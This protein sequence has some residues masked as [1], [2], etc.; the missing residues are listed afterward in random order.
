M[1]TSLRRDEIVQR[2]LALPAEVLSGSLLP[3]DGIAEVV[4]LLGLPASATLVD[5]ACGRGGYRLEVAAR[6]GASLIGIDFSVEAIRQAGQCADALGRDARFVVADIAATGLRTASVDGVMCIDAIHIVAEPADVFAELRRVLRPGGRVVVSN[7]EARDRDN[8]ALPEWVRRSTAPP[9]SPRQGSPTSPSSSGRCG[10]SRNGRCGPKRPSSTRPE[11]TPSPRS[12]TRRSRSCRTSRSHDGCSHRPPR[13][14]TTH[15]RTDPRERPLAGSRR[16]PTRQGVPYCDQEGRRELLEQ[17]RHRCR[18]SGGRGV[19]T[20]GRRATFGARVCRRYRIRPG[21]RLVRVTR[22]RPAGLECLP[23]ASSGAGVPG[24]TGYSTSC[25]PDTD[26]G[27][28]AKRCCCRERD[29]IRRKHRFASVVVAAPSATSSRVAAQTTK[30]GG[31][32]RCWPGCER[33]G[34]T[35]GRTATNNHV[36]GRLRARQPTRSRTGR[37]SRDARRPGASRGRVRSPRPRRRGRPGGDRHQPAP[38]VGRAGRSR[39]VTTTRAPRAFLPSSTGCKRRC[40]WSRSHG[41]RD[42][43]F[44]Q[45]EVRRFSSPTA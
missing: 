17:G 30:V 11:T 10:S 4:E 15:L 45:I 37:R 33:G 28:P 43:P 34:R 9:G 38:A 42:H 20:E 36:H 19:S 41:I 44:S 31:S 14:R 6:T 21:G 2:H 7:W 24:V 3:W 23:I 1:A 13:R 35:V 18:A 40:R 26:I 12:T 22:T 29:R 39:S 32:P 8:D 16:A 27:D 5:L 25:H